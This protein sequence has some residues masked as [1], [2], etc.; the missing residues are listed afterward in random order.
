MKS[1]D[2]LEKTEDDKDVSE[3]TFTQS[4]SCLLTGGVRGYDDDDD[5]DDWPDMAFAVA[6]ASSSSSLNVCSELFSKVHEL[7]C[8]PVLKLCHGK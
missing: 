6:V 4:K 3:A 1:S 7:V 8:S 2:E 5:D